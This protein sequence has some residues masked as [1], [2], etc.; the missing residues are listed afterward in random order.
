MTSGK[1]LTMHLTN[2]ITSTI[3]PKLVDCKVFYYFVAQNAYCAFTC[4]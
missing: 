3:I 1:E 2:Q 4:A